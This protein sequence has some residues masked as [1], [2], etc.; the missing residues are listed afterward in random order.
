MRARYYD[1]S[2]GHFMSEDP[3]GLAAGVN[4][5]LY[6]SADPGDRSDPTGL[7]DYSSCKK[8]QVET[9]D[10][11]TGL[12]VCVRP[13]APVIIKADPNAIPVPLVSV[14]V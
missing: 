1:P 14:P 3:V 12:L 2:V 9:T 7:D 10:P 11:T 6:V 5:Y 13:A 8:G 4:P